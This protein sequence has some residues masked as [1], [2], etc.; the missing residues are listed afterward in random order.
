[1]ATWWGYPTPSTPPAFHASANTAVDSATTDAARDGAD[2]KGVSVA[3]TY[4]SAIGL[5]SVVKFRWNGTGVALIG[6]TPGA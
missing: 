6:K 3:L 1:L 4:P 2:G 5:K